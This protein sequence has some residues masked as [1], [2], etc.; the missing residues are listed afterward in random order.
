MPRV[1]DVL[2]LMEMLGSR[3]ATMTD[4]AKTSAMMALVPGYACDRD[5]HFPLVLALKMWLGESSAHLSMSDEWFQRIEVQTATSGSVGV[6]VS[7]LPRYCGQPAAFLKSFHGL[8]SLNPT[9][10]GLHG[11]SAAVL[12]E[13]VLTT[14]Q[15]VEPLFG[16]VG[17]TATT[18]VTDVP[19]VLPYLVAWGWGTPSELIRPELVVRMIDN[20]QDGDECGVDFVFRR[21]ADILDRHPASTAP[22][23]EALKNAIEGNDL[24]RQ[25]FQERLSQQRVRW[26]LRCAS[27]LVTA[28]CEDGSGLDLTHPSAFVTDIGDDKNIAHIPLA[29]LCRAHM[30]RIYHHRRFLAPTLDCT[31]LPHELVAILASYATPTLA[32][33]ALVIPP[34]FSTPF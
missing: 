20:Y 9:L 18:L 32:R 28:S 15:H 21:I 31:N 24:R 5:A 33:P 1:S 34:W 17:T 14:T 30:R 13:C 16:S 27:A 12:S 6:A 7:M 22:I 29:R 23:H 4:K 3:W 10:R 11:A 26:G 25:W 8:M 2:I 19:G